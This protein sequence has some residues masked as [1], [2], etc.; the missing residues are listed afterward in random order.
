[1]NRALARPR[2]SF[3]IVQALLGLMFL[4]WLPAIDHAGAETSFPLQLEKAFL[5]IDGSDSGETERESG[6]E[7]WSDGDGTS[8]V[9]APADGACPLLINA[10]GAG[11]GIDPWRF[12]NFNLLGSL[13]ATGPPAL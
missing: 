3:A 9:F 12:I 5:L 11:A 1:M 10:R 2:V 6:P 4:A 8:E 7:E 13:R